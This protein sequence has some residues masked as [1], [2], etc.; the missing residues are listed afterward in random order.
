MVLMNI[1]ERKG[2]QFDND[3]ILKKSDRLTSICMS[4][5]EA[6]KLMNDLQMLHMEQDCHECPTENNGEVSNEDHSE[7]V[8]NC[9]HEDSKASSNQV[10][11]PATELANDNDNPESELG[12]PTLHKYSLE[13][14]EKSSLTRNEWQEQYDE[15]EESFKHDHGSECAAINGQV[16]E[17]VMFLAAK[18]LQ[19][20]VLL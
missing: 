8:I 10:N 11:G 5:N 16:G 7:P 12:R 17:T 14:S 15:I 18:S 1:L 3:V 20:I 19:V 9:S 13:S 4:S 6:M 2:Y